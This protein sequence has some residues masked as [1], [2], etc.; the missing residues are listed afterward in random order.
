MRIRTTVAAVSGAVVLSAL[1]VPAAQAFDSHKGNTKITKVVVNGGKDLVIG[2]S[3]K[4]FVITVTGTDPKGIKEGIALAWHGKSYPDRV[5]GLIAPRVDPKCVKLSATKGT[6]KAVVVA[7]PSTLSNDTAGRWKVLAGLLGKGR[8]ENHVIKGKYTTVGVKRAA[9]L[10]VD[11]APEPVEKGESLLVS[12]AL[13]RANWESRKF[14]GYTGQP[15]KLQFKAKGAS[16]Y[17]TLKTVKSDAKGNLK[18]IVKASADGTFRYAFA[19]S[20]TSPAVVSAGD[21]VDVR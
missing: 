12:G 16:S 1:A 11:A 15:V 18:T 21:F 3:K 20:S 7:D 9:K 19:G 5:D 4:K 10:T 6:C 13:T 14:A 17:T 2:T 8:A